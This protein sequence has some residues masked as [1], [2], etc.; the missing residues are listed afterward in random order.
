MN[1]NNGAIM[2]R[3]SFIV[4]PLASS[5]KRERALVAW[6]GV[7]LQEKGIAGCDTW[8]EPFFGT[9][10]V[11]FNAGIGREVVA[12]DA[13]PH[14][15]DF[16]KAI[17]SGKLT[18]NGTREFL[19]EVAMTAVGRYDA[20]TDAITIPISQKEI[21]YNIRDHFNMY[22]DPMMFLFVMLD[23]LGG[24]GRFDWKGRFISPYRERD[25][26]FSEKYIAMVCNRIAAVKSEMDRTAFSFS[27]DDFRTTIGN[28]PAGSIVYCDPPRIG[29]SRSLYDRWSV[30]DESDLRD[31]LE[32]ASSSSGIRFI[33]STWASDDRGGANPMLDS[34]WKGY[35]ARMN[36]CG[37]AR[38]DALITNF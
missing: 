34:V 17:Q 12:S 28:A 3:M 27:A 36:M 32:S 1:D 33:V 29:R 6:I 37:C 30:S 38:K 7:V 10:L 26:R 14:T 35:D 15:I 20:D 24:R 8:V 13:N 18:P 21:Y 22:G 11:G 16:Y 5:R 2:D 31:S 25:G 4:P 19:S 9:G 23:C